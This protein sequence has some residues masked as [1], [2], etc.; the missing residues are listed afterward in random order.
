MTTD[1]TTLTPISLRMVLALCAADPNTPLTP[2]Q[3]ALLWSH[4]GARHADGTYWLPTLATCGVPTQTL[5]RW[6]ASRARMMV[7]QPHEEARDGAAVPV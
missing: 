2:A 4:L 6:Y 7:T 3:K 1:L 5:Q